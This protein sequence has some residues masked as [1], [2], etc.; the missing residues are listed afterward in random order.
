MI[1]QKEAPAATEATEVKTLGK[2]TVEMLKDELPSDKISA[3]CWLFHFGFKVIPINPQTKETARK[4]TFIDGLTIDR[5][6]S[7]WSQHPDHDIGA[8]IDDS[9]LVLDADSDESLSALNELE[10]AYGISPNLIVQTRKGEHHYFKRAAGT[11]AKMRGFSTDTHPTAI[12][13]KTARSSTDGRAMIVLPP[14]TNKTIIW[15]ESDTV[16]DLVEVDQAFIDAVFHHNGDE[17]PRPPTEQAMGVCTSRAGKHEANEIV[18][19]INPALNYGDWLIILMG[20]HSRSNGDDVGLEIADNWSKG[21]ANYCGR[22]E[23]EYKWRSFEV[24]GGVNFGSVCRFA[25]LAGADL[26]A[27]GAK[28]DENGDPLPTF[29]DLLILINETNKETPPAIVKSL[30]FKTASLGEIERDK[31]QKTIALNTGG[32]IGAIRK[33]AKDHKV[34]QKKELFKKKAGIVTVDPVPP[35]KWID[36]AFNE[37]TGAIKVLATIPNIELMLTHYKITTYYDVI[38]KKVFIN[39]P[40]VTGSPDNIDN[41]ALTAC[42]S[43]AKLNEL[44][45]DQV[46]AYIYAIADTNQRNPVADWITAT[47]W[48]GIDRLNDLFNTLQVRPDYPVTLRNTVVRRWLISAVAAA[49]KPMGFKARGVLTLQGAQSIGKTSWLESLV[50]DLS[51]RNRIVKTDHLLDPS[52]K[53]SVMGAVSHWLVELGELDST[54]KKDVARLKGFIT[55]DMDKLRRPYAAVDSEYQRR[56]VFFASVND[57]K[58]LVDDTGNTR[59]WTLAVEAINFK[60]GIDMQ[61][62]WAQVVT[63]YEAGDQW[64]LTK[65]EESQLEALNK[66][67][68]VVTA[69]RDAIES[70]FDFGSTALQSYKSMSA[71][72][73]LREIGYDKPTNP[74]CTEAGK[75]LRELIGE[76]NKKSRWKVPPASCRM[77]DNT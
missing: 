63:L 39:V 20:L 77:F 40:N 16:A 68:R 47:E 38:K 45:V 19:Y 15:N 33:V 71:T 56:T 31:L 44:S 60:H 76:P 32:S 24:G 4:W 53:D 23:L 49:L 35:Y 41:T 62:L 37:E 26:K 30:V 70:H 34:Q 11:Y 13:V 18:S 3:A 28:Y 64:W 6:V 67:H 10:K 69:V 65:E 7:H 2:Y 17:A 61:Q 14:S 59:F 74:Q 51:L 22:E 72:D 21:A 25:E 55:A 50:P 29:E 75:A 57:S 66:G 1:E 52:N 73:V 27:I 58:F 5:I 12:D 48:D 54:F 8:I 9:I 46:P 43:M 42:I 36:T